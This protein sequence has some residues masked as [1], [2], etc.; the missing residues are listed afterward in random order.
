MNKKYI[1]IGVFIIAI[2]ALLAFSGG[3]RTQEL[4]GASF[5]ETYQKTAGAVLLDVRTPGEFASGHLEGA[6]NVDFNNPTFSEEMQ[7]LDKEKPYFVYC[8][9]GNRSGQ[10]IA[11]MKNGGFKNLVELQGGI[12]SNQ[13]ALTL[14]TTIGAQQN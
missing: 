12:V 10:A 5:M 8:R 7:K 13:G 9:S 4:S 1:G 14:V 3:A 11:M 6:L 2:V